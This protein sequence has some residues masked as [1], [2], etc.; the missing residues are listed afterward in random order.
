MSTSSRQTYQCIFFDLDHTLWDY[1]ANSN[2]TLQELYNH[3]AL[4]EKGVTSVEEFLDRFKVVNTQLWDLYDNGKIESHIIR[5]QRFKQI[6]TPFSAYEEK[7][8][9]DLSRD[10]LEA[11][12]KKSALMPFATEILD[13]LKDKYKLTLI[14][15]GFEEIQH[16]KLAAGKIGHYFNHIITSQKAGH[17]KPAREIFD[18]ALQCNAIENHQAVMIGDNPITDMGGAINASI[19]TIFFNPEKTAHQAPV[20]HE[21]SCLSELRQIL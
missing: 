7:L 17:K 12:P 10:Y 16:T 11:C 21:I 5:E 3:Y 13:Y 6:L 14:T 8:S 20:K 2:E 15:N 4:K 1:E 19:D 9:E 18:F